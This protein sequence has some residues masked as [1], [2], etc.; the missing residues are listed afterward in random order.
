[1]SFFILFFRAGIEGNK[2]SGGLFVRPREIPVRVTRVTALH[3]P[4]AGFTPVDKSPGRN[5]A[6]A[7]RG[8]FCFFLLLFRNKGNDQLGNICH[9]H[10][11]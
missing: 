7:F 10:G 3:L 4:H 6:V 1:M 2:Q 5:C 9:S 11:L 8:S